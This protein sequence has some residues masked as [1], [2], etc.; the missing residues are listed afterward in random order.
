M[1]D[2]GK[3]TSTAKGS[4]KGKDSP[5]AAVRESKH[6]GMSSVKKL[7]PRIICVREKSTFYES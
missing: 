7:G 4:L 3:R 2:G 6:K 1:R 5:A